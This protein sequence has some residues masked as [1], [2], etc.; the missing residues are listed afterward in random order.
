MWNEALHCCRADVRELVEHIQ[1]SAG[2]PL[3]RNVQYDGRGW[4]QEHFSLGAVAIIPDDAYLV[5]TDRLPVAELHA[6]GCHGCDSCGTAIEIELF[7]RCVVGGEVREPAIWASL[8]VNDGREWEAFK[9]IY[10]DWRGLFSLLFQD[11]GIRFFMSAV[12]P[13]MDRTRSKKPVA[14]LDA[15][16]SVKDLNMDDAAFALEFEWSEDQVIA[17]RSFTVLAVLFTCIIKSV[18][19]RSKGRHLLDAWIAMRD[20]GG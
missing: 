20:V 18:G 5:K 10:H 2:Y 6:R 12:I 17:L 14:R 8:K 11:T 1:E 16:F 9:R 3:L 13:E 15:L 7:R 4:I 19:E